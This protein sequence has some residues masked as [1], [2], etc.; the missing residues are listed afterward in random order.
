MRAAPCHVSATGI[1]L[2][3]IDAAAPDRDVAAH[4]L[5]VEHGRSRFRRGEDCIAALVDAAHDTAGERLQR[6][7]V[8]IIEI[9]VEPRVDGCD[10]RQSCAAAPRSPHGGRSCPGPRSAPGSARMPQGRDGFR[11]ETSPMRYS[12]RPG[13]GTEGTL[14]RSPVGSNAGVR[15]SANRR[16]PL[17]PGATN[18]RPAGSAPD[19]RRP[20]HNCNC[21]KTG[22]R[23]S[24][25]CTGSAISGE[26][27]KGNARPLMI[28]EVKTGLPLVARRDARL[29]I[30]G[31]L[32]GDASLAA[33][34]YYAHPKN[35]FWRLV[36]R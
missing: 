28:D 15:S 10:N 19:W 3:A 20:E 5:G 30:L 13:T 29:F 27:R 34:Q 26:G 33:R 11:T 8:I 17:R 24:L 23:G 25:G 32:P 4:P 12:G 35:Q 14:T 36:G 2:V 18:S 22:R 9:G 16:V 21:P 31:S 1:E 6:L 7:Q